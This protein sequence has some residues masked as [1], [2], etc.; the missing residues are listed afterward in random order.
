VAFDIDKVDRDVLAYSV[1][2]ICGTAS[3][4]STAE[5]LV[6]A[7]DGAS[8]SLED[9]LDR[10][11]LCASSPDQ[12]PG[13]LTRREFDVACLLGKGLT[14]KEIAQRLSINPATVKNHVH[15]VLTKL[16]LARREQVPERLRQLLLLLAEAKS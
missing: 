5:D 10:N 7:L 1:G 16:E 15:S 12:I 14:N 4:G 2:V 3:T 8:R 6:K 9:H 13:M 11:A